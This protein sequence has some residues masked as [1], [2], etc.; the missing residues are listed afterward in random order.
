MDVTVNQLDWKLRSDPR[1]VQV[2]RNAR[3]MKKDDTSDSAGFVVMDL[4]FISATKVLPAIVPLAE[5]GAE[6]LILIKPQFELEKADVAKGGIVR[7]PDLHK[8]AIERVARAAEAAG[9]DVLSTRPSCIKGA[10]G[11]QEFFLHAR[12]RE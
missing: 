11:N 3:F 8:K 2:E 12:R 9:L 1:V 10:E 4:S 7:S 5:K 6:F